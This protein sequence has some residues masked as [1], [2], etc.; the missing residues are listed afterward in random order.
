MTDAPDIRLLSLWQPWA[1]LVAIKEKGAETRDWLTAY[2]GW[3]AIHAAKHWDAESV[4][5]CLSKPFAQ[6]L[7]THGYTITPRYRKTATTNLPLGGIV[8]VAYINGS[9]RSLGSPPIRLTL[10]EHERAFGDW[11]NG[12]GII[13]FDPDKTRKLPQMIPYRATQ[14]VLRPVEGQAVLDQLLRHML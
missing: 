9:F 3:V 12:R 7:T 4:D 6:V 2:R 8:A 1:T 13:T 11:R 14:S 10:P 5:I